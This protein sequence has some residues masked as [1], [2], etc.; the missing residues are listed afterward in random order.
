MLINAPAL[1]GPILVQ[2][3]WFFECSFE[4]F[5]ENFSSTFITKI[6]KGGFK[7]A[8]KRSKFLPQNRALSPSSPVRS[9]SASRRFSDGNTTQSKL[10]GEISTF[11]EGSMSEFF[12][13]YAT[14][15]GSGP[16]WKIRGIL[17]LLDML[18]EIIDWG[19]ETTPKSR[20]QVSPQ[21]IKNVVLMSTRALLIKNFYHLVSVNNSKL[22][23]IS[24]KKLN[25]FTHKPLVQ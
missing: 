22:I 24:L 11:V 21:V 15:L 3:I 14:Q 10:H 18:D 17:I 12:W 4:S 6:F 25:A 1:R 9:F 16:K 5:F 19:I 2:K 8:F 20:T 23:Y 7:G 13:Y